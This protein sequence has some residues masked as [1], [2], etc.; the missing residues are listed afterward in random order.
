MWTG[1]LLVSCLA[2][3]LLCRISVFALNR[4]FYVF[5]YHKGQLNHRIGLRR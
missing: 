4:N 5:A 1:F 3:L 2:A